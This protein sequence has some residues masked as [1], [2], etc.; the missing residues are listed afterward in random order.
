MNT[1]SF[2]A[3]L[4]ASV[5]AAIL[6]SHAQQHI[7]QPLEVSFMFPPESPPASGSVADSYA[8]MNNYVIK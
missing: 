1:R 2:F 3:P 6:I 8:W 4:L 7:E 5:A